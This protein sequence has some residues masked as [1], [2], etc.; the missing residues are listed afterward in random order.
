ML[1]LKIKINRRR[2]LVK[3]IFALALWYV[4]PLN[5]SLAGDGGQ[6]YIS[7]LV[8]YD[9]ESVYFYRNPR[10]SIF[11]GVPTIENFRE[12]VKK[13]K[14]ELKNNSKEIEE[15]IEFQRKLEKDHKIYELEK[16]L[17]L[18]I[19]NQSSILL[20][21]INNIPQEILKDEEIKKIFTQYVNKLFEEKRKEL[22]TQI[23]ERYGLRQ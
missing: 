13:I 19:D 2:E 20:K 11:L 5:V 1:Y 4:L 17:N 22:E 12:S 15:L 10:E 23:L 16:R 3:K 8:L 21:E 14:D 18:K 6:E 7:N 9:P